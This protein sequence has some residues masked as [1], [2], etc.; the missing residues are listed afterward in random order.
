MNTPSA[1]ILAISVVGG[2]MMF[3]IL[4]GHVTDDFVHKGSGPFGPDPPEVEQM[5]IPFAC[6]PGL[7]CSE[8]KTSIEV[9]GRFG[10][11][12]TAWVEWEHCPKGCVYRG[13]GGN[14]WPHCLK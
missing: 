12:G 14:A 7:R 4:I 5:E 2:L 8:K 13:I 11:R 6:E 9:C 10:K 1:V 3:V